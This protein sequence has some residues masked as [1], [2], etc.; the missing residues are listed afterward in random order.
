MCS[1]DLPQVAA[2]AA[3]M[4]S[5][6]VTTN[7]ED[8]LA[9]LNATATDL[10]TPG[11]D[12]QF[13]YG[14]IN[15]AAALGAPAISDREGIQVYSAD[16]HAYGVNTTGNAFVSYLPEGAYTLISGTDTNGNSVY[17]EQGEANVTLPFTLG[18]NTPQVRLG[19]LSSPVHR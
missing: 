2:L 7:A 10:G 15:P 8:T 14:M 11:R 17:G 13:G 5:K 19:V 1:S 12:D 16:G 6:G 18:P 3:L 9:R 4:L